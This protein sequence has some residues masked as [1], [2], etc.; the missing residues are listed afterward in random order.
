M[1]TKLTKEERSKLASEVALKRWEEKR[2][3]EAAE[4]APTTFDVPVQEATPPP[5]QPT[6]PVPEPP[7]RPR[8]PRMVRELGV[9]NSYAQKRLAEAIK[10][11]A[12]A[13]NKVGMLNAEIPSL[14][15]IIKALGNTPDLAGMQDF[16]AQIPGV[17]YVPPS[18]TQGGIDPAMLAPALPA[19]PLA[20]GGGLGVIPEANVVDEDQ[21]LRGD[22]LTAGGGWR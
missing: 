15:A 18:M 21:F 3:R 20:R 16:T 8:K 12:I 10:E 9:A 19:V 13:M 7:R 14:V 11:R 2:K 1:G 4:S 6:A 17:P 5:P 22:G